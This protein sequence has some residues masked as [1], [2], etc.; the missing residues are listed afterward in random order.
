MNKVVLVTGGCRSGKSAWAQRLAE[1]TAAPRLYLATAPV[2]DDE[3]R[4]RIARH[5][6]ERAN[7]DW[8]TIEEQI[9]MA[10]V[11]RNASENVV[12]V[13]CLTTWICNLMFQT[14]PNHLDEDTIAAHCETLRQACAATRAHVIFVTN[15][16]GMGVV[17]P[18]ADGRLFRD[19]SGRCNQDM[20]AFADM[21]VFMACGLPLFLKGSADA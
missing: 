13:D 21:V 6:R 3:M 14:K 4:A 1:Q 11:L 19:L 7:R 9:E 10:T 15:E 17:P 16:V 8:N 5:R 18:S 20:A 12:L 2:L